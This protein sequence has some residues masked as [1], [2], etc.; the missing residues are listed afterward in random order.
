MKKGILAGAFCCFVLT[1]LLSGQENKYRIGP[2]DVLQIIVWKQP[3]FSHTLTVSGAGTVYFPFLG[4]IEVG[5]RTLI[6]VERIVRERLAQEYLKDPKVGVILKESNSRKFCIFG[7]VNNPGVYRIRS[8]TPI[9][10]VLLSE[11]GGLTEQAGALLLITRE[12]S[13]SGTPGEGDVRTV[14]ETIRVDL[15]KLLKQGERSQNVGVIAGDVIFVSP[16][17]EK[18]VYILGQV[19]SPGPYTIEG[20]ITVLEAI[21]MAGGFGPSAARHKIEVLRE[22]NGEKR[23]I[24]V[25]VVEIERKG[26]LGQ[27]IILEPGDVITIPE[28]WF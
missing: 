27:D 23:K 12:K 25:N 8:E 5:G 15:G 13:V 21:K 28:S 16:R 7:E 10:E 17:E 2:E 9:L 11:A 19:K 1:G 14:S 4:E 20:D 18:Q 3:D 6:E 22:E 24:R 26:K